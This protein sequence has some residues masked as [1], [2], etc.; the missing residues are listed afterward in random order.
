MTDF[1]SHNGME[2]PGTKVR[3]ELA[4]VAN[5]PSQASPPGTVHSEAQLQYCKREAVLDGRSLQL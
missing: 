4:N 5:T 3:G 2:H 1:K